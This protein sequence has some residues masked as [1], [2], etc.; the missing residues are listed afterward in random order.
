MKKPKGRKF[1]ETVP[2]TDHKSETDLRNATPVI[3]TPHKKSNQD[4]QLQLRM[5]EIWV[6]VA[7]VA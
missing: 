6:R 4:F 2:L 1:R 7:T 5:D 3:R